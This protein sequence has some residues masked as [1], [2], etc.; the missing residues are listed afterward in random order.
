MASPAG[1]S[2]SVCLV[3]RE[4]E[5]LYVKNKKNGITQLKL[6]RNMVFVYTKYEKMSKYNIN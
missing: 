6:G 1:S 5:K 2:D 3:E 4:G